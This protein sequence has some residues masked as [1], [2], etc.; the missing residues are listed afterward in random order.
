[1]HKPPLRAVNLAL[2]HLQYLGDLLAGAPVIP[3]LR[4]VA[5]EQNQCVDDFLRCMLA[6]AHQT[7]QLLGF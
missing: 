5:V 6:F 7:L 3:T 4:W 2:S 1:L